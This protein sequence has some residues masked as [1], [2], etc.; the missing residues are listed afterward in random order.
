MYEDGKPVEEYNGNRGLDD[1]KQFLRKHVKEEAKDVSIVEVDE[2]PLPV[3][4]TKGELLSIHDQANFFSTLEQGPAFI[5]FFAPWCGHC[6]R[7][8]P[9][10]V[11]L[12]AHLK[13]KVTVAEVD[14]D[15]HSSLCAAQ[16]IQ[17]YPT[18]V[19][20]SGGIRSEYTGGR[21]LDQLKAFAE[22]ASEGRLHPLHSDSE[23]AQHVK[24]QSV[25]YLFLYST[26]NAGIVVCA[27][28]CIC[29]YIS[30]KILA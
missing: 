3:L 5:K 14:C 15:A 16:K 30:H 17:G 25:V 8:A 21:K 18:L 13:N 2:E 19:Y 12:A 29:T 11:Q 1:L 24:E 4:N 9:T 10:W 6:K 28:S 22:K 27:L 26:S 7:L 23:L 20:F